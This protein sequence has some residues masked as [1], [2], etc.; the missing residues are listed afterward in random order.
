MWGKIGQRTNKT[1]VQE[2]DDP[3][4][5]TAC[6]E[7]DKFDIRCVGVLTEESVEIHHKREVED[8]PVS[9]NLNIFVAC[10]TTCWAR[11]R[12]YEALDFLQDRG[13]Y[14][15]TDSFV[16]KS[17]PRQPDPPLGDYL[18]NFKDELSEGDY[19]VAFAFGG[20]KNYPSWHTKASKN[21]RCVGYSWTV[22]APNNSTMLSSV[23]TCYTTFNN[24]KS[25][26]FVKQTW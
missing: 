15:D 20:P 7:S 8:D 26:G 22:R 18:G 11:L 25:R 10:F 16:F 5:F 3:Q 21:V 9:P 24:H 12:L 1:Q 2:F 23:R 6:L 19:I 17:L 13:A 4:K 14:F